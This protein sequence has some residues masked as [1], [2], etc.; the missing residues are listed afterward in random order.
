M[1][2]SA[3]C[4]GYKWPVLTATRIWKSF[5]KYEWCPIKLQFADLHMLVAA[6]EGEI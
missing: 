6:K 2:P 4:G 5:L 1:W 3:R